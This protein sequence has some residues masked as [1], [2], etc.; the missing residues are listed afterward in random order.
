MVLICSFLRSHELSV[1]TRFAL[2]GQYCKALLF[3]APNIQNTLGGP[4]DPSGTRTSTSGT[5]KLSLSTR[6]SVTP[7]CAVLQFATKVRAVV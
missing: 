2:V 1:N 6:A 7:D 4:L 3:L 5:A